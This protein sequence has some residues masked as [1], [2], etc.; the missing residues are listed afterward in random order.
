MIIE[1]HQFNVHHAMLFIT[2]SC[3]PYSEQANFY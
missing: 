3:L 1:T 2:W